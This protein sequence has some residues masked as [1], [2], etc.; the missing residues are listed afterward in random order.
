M[1]RCYLKNILKF[2]HNVLELIL[3]TRPIYLLRR[4]VGRVAVAVDHAQAHLFGA[5]RANR[6]TLPATLGQA[7]S[8][9]SFL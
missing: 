3:A 4:V 1:L 7:K 6:H 5:I 8:S 2:R 9:P